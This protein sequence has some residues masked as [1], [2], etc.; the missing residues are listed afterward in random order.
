LRYVLGAQCP[1][2]KLL[3]EGQER[4]ILWEEKEEGGDGGMR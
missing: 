1:P 2:T 4:A 3:T